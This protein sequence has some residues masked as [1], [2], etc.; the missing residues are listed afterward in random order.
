MVAPVLRE[1]SI[2]GS[3]GLTSG[4]VDGSALFIFVLLTQSISMLFCVSELCLTAVVLIIGNN[5]SWGAC[6]SGKG[7][8]WCTFRM[9]LCPQIVRV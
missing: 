9:Y 2:G 1:W 6:A 5:G 8:S 4:D 7:L 3:G